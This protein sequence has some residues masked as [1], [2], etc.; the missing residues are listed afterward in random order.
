MRWLPIVLSARL[1]APA[2][3]EPAAR[4]YQ[5]PTEIVPVEQPADAKPTPPPRLSTHM[6]EGPAAPEPLGPMPRKR[7]TPGFG[8]M[9]TGWTIFGVDYA[10]SA[11]S[12]ILWGLEPDGSLGPPVPEFFIPFVGELVVTAQMCRES[13]GGCSGR[14][15]SGIMTYAVVRTLAQLV[16]VTLGIIGTIRYVRARKRY[17]RSKQQR[18]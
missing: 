9:V 12:G 6:P 5:G 14:E 15:E 7:H 13:S 10:W 3:E 16:G 1:A 18:R 4:D 17:K 11:T 2:A 8:M